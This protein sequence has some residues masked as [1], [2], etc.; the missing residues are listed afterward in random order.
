MLATRV[1]FVQ[2]LPMAKSGMTTST[3]TNS[4]AFA[5]P[6]AD[7]VALDLAPKLS[8][9]KEGPWTNFVIEGDNS[10]A[11]RYLRMTFAGAPSFA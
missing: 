2:V 5:G 9:G 6:N 1:I 10:D 11:L 7:F 4:C 8:V 3:K